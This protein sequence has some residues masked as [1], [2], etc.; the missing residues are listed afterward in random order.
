MIAATEVFCWPAIR[1]KVDSS[2]GSRMRENGCFGVAPRGPR[3]MGKASAAVRAVRRMPSLGPRR[4]GAPFALVVVFLGIML[5][6]L[7]LITDLAGLCMPN[8]QSDVNSKF[9]NFEDSAAVFSRP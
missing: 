3:L 9:K 6:C 8:S 4:L 7:G 5:P 1:F 2:S